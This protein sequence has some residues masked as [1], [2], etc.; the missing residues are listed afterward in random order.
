MIFQAGNIG[1]PGVIH[2][3]AGDPHAVVEC[4]RRQRGREVS[5]QSRDLRN[6]IGEGAHVRSPLA[7]RSSSAATISGTPGTR[8]PPK[9]LASAEDRNIAIVPPTADRLPM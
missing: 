9:V 6:R 5:L 3:P 4:C 1:L 2:Q 8:K 7:H